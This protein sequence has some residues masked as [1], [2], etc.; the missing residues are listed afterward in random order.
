MIVACN[1]T[2][3]DVR[4]LFRELVDVKAEVSFV[5]IFE[6]ETNSMC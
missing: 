3:L 6:R 5:F 1:V 4:I 2:V